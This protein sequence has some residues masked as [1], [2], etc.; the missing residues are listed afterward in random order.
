MLLFTVMARSSLPRSMYL[1]VP[2]S[3]SPFVVLCRLIVLFC[4]HFSY[5]SNF[6]S[7]ARC[8]QGAHRPPILRTILCYAS[9]PSPRPSIQTDPGPDQLR[10]RRPLLFGTRKLWQF[11]Y[12]L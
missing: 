11:E 3:R 4:P 2:P 7:S 10:S 8:G 5:V 6:S 12:D 1:V 9:S